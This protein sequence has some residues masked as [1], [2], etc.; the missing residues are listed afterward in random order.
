[1]IDIVRIPDERKS[2]LIGKD[3]SVKKSLE[4][5][6]KTK[7]NVLDDVEISGEVELF[8]EPGEVQESLHRPLCPVVAGG[9]HGELDP[10]VP[11]AVPPFLA[12]GLGLGWHVD[13][14]RYQHT[15][16][17]CQSQ[18]YCKSHLPSSSFFFFS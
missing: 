1:M 4:D 13:A 14:D 11:A 12:V 8:D 5:R 6:T 10:V 17:Q 2:I 16:C 9:V 3:G 18:D 7:I 15:D